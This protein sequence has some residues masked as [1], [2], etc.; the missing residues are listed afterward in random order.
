M[1]ASD[2]LQGISF[3]IAENK[4]VGL[5]GRSGSGKSTISK[6]IQHLITN[7]KVLFSEIDIVFVCRIDSEHNCMGC[8]I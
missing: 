6:L 5:V 3:E 7:Q 1:D 8:N 4:V 2:L